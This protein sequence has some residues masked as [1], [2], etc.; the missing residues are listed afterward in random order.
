MSESRVVMD[1]AFGPRAPVSL[2]PRPI[3]VERGHSHP[4][5]SPLEGE[6]WRGGAGGIREFGAGGE[7]GA[8]PPVLRTSP[9][10]GE[11]TQA[12]ALMVLSTALRPLRR[13]R[14]E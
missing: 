2:P 5:L 3:A 6:R 7:A 4:A 1:I 14:D 11:G 13:R 12:A 9:S 8:P 10:R